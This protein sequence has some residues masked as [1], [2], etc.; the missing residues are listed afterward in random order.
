V[1]NLPNACTTKG[2][3]Q[4][5]EDDADK[6]RNAF[7]RQSYEV[8]KSKFSGFLSGAFEN[9]VL[10]DIALPHRVLVGQRCEIV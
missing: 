6:R 7:D 4:D 5:T 2:N 8:W 3:L 9:P 10:P 1:R